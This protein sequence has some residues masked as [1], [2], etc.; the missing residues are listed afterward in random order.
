[1]ALK[2]NFNAIDFERIFKEKQKEVE[3]QIVRVLRY[4]GDLAVNEAKTNGNYQD[5]T[6]N[7]RNS[8]GFVIAIDGRIVDEDF[9]LTA[10]GSKPD[11]INSI[12][13][14]GSKCVILSYL[15]N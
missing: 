3:N 5:Q 9:S 15:K 12:C 11:M 14:F 8:I 7:L 6:A 10:K 4:V 2:A 1:M 13:R